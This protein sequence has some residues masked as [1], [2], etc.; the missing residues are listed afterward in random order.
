LII[1]C[2]PRL[3]S[4]S[5]VCSVLSKRPLSPA[6]GATQRRTP[7]PDIGR[8]VPTI[9]SCPQ[10]IS[11]L[12]SRFWFWTPTHCM[13]QRTALVNPAPEYDQHVRNDQEW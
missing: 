6:F 7:P 8:R 13:C 4:G 2:L 12:P 1:H 9:Y 10:S 3:L 11:Q 5:I